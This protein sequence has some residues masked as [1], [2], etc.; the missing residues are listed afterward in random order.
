MNDNNSNPSRSNTEGISS[1]DST[2]R[3]STT[4]R[5]NL[6]RNT[7][8]NVE[9]I[10]RQLKE[11]PQWICWKYAER[12]NKKG[13][14]KL[15]KPPINPKTGRLAKTNDLTTCSDFQTA[16]NYA[17]TN[18][19]K[20]SG[21]G[22]VFAKGDE[23][24]GIDIDHCSKNDE[25]SPAAQ[26]I[27]EYFHPTFCEK[28]PGGDGLH[29]FGLGQLPSDRKSKVSIATEQFPEQSIEWYDHTSP[30]YLTVT[31]DKLADWVGSDV[32]DCNGALNW[33]YYEY[34][35]RLPTKELKKPTPKSD[36]LPS[37]TPT[38]SNLSDDDIITICQ[39]ARN[40]S[41]F[42]GLWSGGGD[43]DASRGDLALCGILAFYTHS[44]W[45]G[46]DSQ[47]DS[48]FRRSGRMRPKWDTKHH[49]DGRTYG[50]GT[51]AKATNGL[52]ATYVKKPEPFND[53]VLNLKLNQYD[54]PVDCLHNIVQI[55]LHYPKW[56]GVI[57]YDE[58]ALRIV[59]R[60]LPP[61]PN[62]T[63][64]SWQDVDNHKTAVWIDNHF[65]FE[66]SENA[67]QRAIMM[68]AEYQ[69]YHPI[70]EYLASLKWDGKYRARNWIERYMGAVETP[71]NRI[72]QLCFLISAIAR[73]MK[74]GC[75]V[76]TVLILE[77][78]QGILKSTALKVLFGDEWF[79]DSAFEL[80]SKDG[81]LAMRGKWCIEMAELDKLKKAEA[82]KAKAFF[83]QRRDEYR[84]PYGRNMMDVPRQCVFAG[85]VNEGSY[86]VDPTG[87]RRYMPVKVTKINLE[88]L[89]VDRDQIW[90]EAFH[91][92][93]L[94]EKWWFDATL[95]YIQAAQDERY[96]ADPWEDTIRLF[97]DEGIDGP[98]NKVHTSDL[99]NCIGIELE[100]FGKLEHNR[101]KG[102]ME[103]LG[104][105][106]GRQTI[107]GKQLNGYARK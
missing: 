8:V 44:D 92:Y 17:Q 58:F 75:K 39:K 84:P 105:K 7:I 2:I 56:R 103:H 35:N 55:L 41:K 83:S 43:G 80:G 61:L 27:L 11:R 5:S 19:N 53:D 89:Q 87:G 48:L 96:D 100:R 46:G 47:L 106:Y 4:S 64:G 24:W 10:P 34:F 73:V 6:Q 40:A 93:Q 32:L 65:G 59:K 21:I 97:L 99:Q 67:T 42:E 30:R 98:L 79:T 26:E 37:P 12:K 33:L 74:P 14:V 1:G 31:G 49:S 107:D 70:R 29:F 62:P 91:L 13:G 38:Q 77:G 85:T 50:Q 3:N 71:A 101:I 25:L 102:I 78:L 18:P 72:F 54:K 52:S 88:A 90:A 60:K 23:L 15:T 22:F 82:S 63:L 94:G 28:S 86:L 45:G 20:V 81:F 36:E 68:V 76:D 69:Q 104:W 51:I 66:P 9:N 16:V 57:A 95:D